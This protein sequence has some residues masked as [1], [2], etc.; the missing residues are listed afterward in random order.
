LECYQVTRGAYHVGDLTRGS[1]KKLIQNGHASCTE[2]EGFL[3]DIVEDK[4]D[5]LDEDWNKL[6]EQLEKTMLCLESFNGL[7]SCLW[8]T[9]VDQEMANKMVVEAASYLQA[10]LA[11]WHFLGLS[12]MPKVHLLEDHVLLQMIIENWLWNKDEESPPKGA[13]I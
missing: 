11:Y 9:P 1:I 4:D 12:V 7:F 13:D 2:L 8:S 3:Y 10:G 5:L 6:A